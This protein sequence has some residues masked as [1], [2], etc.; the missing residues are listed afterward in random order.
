MDIALLRH[1]CLKLKMLSRKLKDGTKFNLLGLS[2]MLRGSLWRNNAQVI[3][4]I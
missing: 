2:K 3:N 4:K 1:I